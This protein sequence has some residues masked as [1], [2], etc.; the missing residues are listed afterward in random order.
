MI[1]FF[2]MKIFGKK[3]IHLCSRFVIFRS[4]LLA[5]LR[6][7]LYL[8]TAVYRANQG[9]HGFGVMNSNCNLYMYLGLCSLFVLFSV[10]RWADFL[11]K[12][13]LQT[14]KEFIL[15]LQL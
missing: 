5:F 14:F 3:W 12:K 8:I 6:V 10:S 15:L 4:Y 7:L 13:F 9:M 1:P 2:L 11:S